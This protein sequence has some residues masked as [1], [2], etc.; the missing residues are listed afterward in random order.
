MDLTAD[1]IGVDPMNSIANRVADYWSRR[2]Q[3]AFVAT[4]KGVFA[5]NAAAP[6]G[7]DTHVI[8]D[9]T[10]NISGGAFIDGVT[11]FSAE[12]FIDATLTMGDSMD[13][14]AMVM[15]HSVVYGRMQKNN[16]IDFIP[17]STN[18]DAARIPTFLGRTVIVDDSMPVTTGVFD[19]WLFG[20]GAV[21]MGIGA[22]KVPTEIDRK[23]EQGNGGGRDILFNRTEWCI[24]PAGCSYVATAPNGGPSNAATATNLAHLDSWR[25][26]W[27]ER[28]QTKIARLITREF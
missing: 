18:P 5:D 13:M 10:V 12:A 27:P 6:A 26:V 24:H 1:L 20:T 11:N 25:R 3:A 16:L 14:L 21:R 23:P 19:T 8:N 2:L 17:D 15:V 28:K 22:P 7:A 4:I 9:M